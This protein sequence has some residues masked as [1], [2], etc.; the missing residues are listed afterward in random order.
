MD[1]RR[2]GTRAGGASFYPGASPSFWGTHMHNR[3]NHLATGKRSNRERK[4]T[5][6]NPKPKQPTSAPGPAMRAKA[7][8]AESPRAPLGSFPADAILPAGRAPVADCGA[9]TVLARKENLVPRGKL[10]GGRPEL[11]ERTFRPGPAPI[12]NPAAT[13]DSTAVATDTPALPLPAAPEPLVISDAPVPRERAL[14]A[15]SDGLPSRI[16][17]WLSRMTR[18]GKPAA[19][20]GADDRPDVALLR[21]ELRELRAQLAIARRMAERREELVRAR[22]L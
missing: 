18:P 4:H 16:M 21:A 22:L 19:V 10:V 9:I 11:L 6:R 1:A 12:E 13:H 14:V 7:K 8:A 15:P 3:R 17:R 5:D 20:P 2:S